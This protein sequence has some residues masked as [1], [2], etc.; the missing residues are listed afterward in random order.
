ML[1][2]ATTGFICAILTLSTTAAPR[3]VLYQ[4]GLA[5]VEEEREFTLAPEGA[6]VIED[7]PQGI[8]L[9]SLSIQGITV[10]SL[11]P[12]PS[13]YSDVEQLVGKYVEVVSPAGTFRGRVA[14]A[15]DGGIVLETE[16][17]TVF[18]RDYQALKFPYPPRRRVEVRYRA[19][20]PGK[21]TLQLRYLTTGLSWSAHYRAVLEGERLELVGT[22]TL[23][24]D[25]GLSFPA[26]QVELVAGQVYTPTPKAADYEVRA[27]AA[28]PEAGVTS[29]GEY[30]R[31][32]LP[33][34]VDLEPG[35]VLVPLVSAALP[36]QR[37]YRF[38][39]GAVETVIRFQNTALPL[40]AGEISFYEE[41][42]GL[43]VGAAPI[44][45]T[46]VGGEVELAIGAAFDLTGVRTQVSHVRLGDDLY[47]DTYRIAIRSAK[48]EPV[49]VE[50]VE[51]LTGSW[52]ITHSSLPYEQL[53]AH[54]VLF[55]LSVPAGGEAEVSYT[56]EWGYR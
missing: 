17:G 24:N 23:V 49:E 25:T 21:K 12:V 30:H 27:L 9:E 41:G 32:S 10:L 36:Y 11:S 22:A 5:L 46:P 4:Q 7:L 19:A 42:G 37:V 44:G 16:T 48:D 54:T 53:D 13:R 14:S 6:L 28:A 33:Q 26:A 52:S 34:P 3:I 8:V 1:R 18:L 2:L 56:V 29:A 55:R 15:G 39:G 43:F 50:V 51:T 40:P 38:Q 35:T 45:H 31:Y 20:E 47:R